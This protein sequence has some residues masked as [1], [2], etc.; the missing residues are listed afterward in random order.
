MTIEESLP[1]A[2]GYQLL[3]I[4]TSYYPLNNWLLWTTIGNL[5]HSVMNLQWLKAT[6]HTQ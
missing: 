4:A 6:L 2:H 5:G 3:P 1:S